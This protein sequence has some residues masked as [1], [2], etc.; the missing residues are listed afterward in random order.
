M[1]TPSDGAAVPYRP[2]WVDRLTAWIG[3]L[4]GPAFLYYLGVGLALIGAVAAS[5]WV[6]GVPFPTIRPFYIFF[7]AIIPYTLGLIHLLDDMA[8]EA[9][10]RFDPVLLADDAE[11]RTMSYRLST[12]PVG[13][14]LVATLLGLLVGLAFALLIPL[15]ERVRL[16]GLAISPTSE[17]VNSGLLVVSWATYGVLFY[18]T[19]HQ[20]REIT[21]VL[22]SHTRINL[23]EVSPIYGFSGVTALT[24]VGIGLVSLGWLIT[25]PQTAG[26]FAG[27][28]PHLIFILAAVLAFLW[29]LLDV[30]RLLN[31]EKDRLLGQNARL[32]ET[33]GAELHRRV[34][35]GE[36]A[37]MSDI[38]DALTGLETER[39]LIEGRPT[40]PWSPQTP[41]AVAA[42]L[43]LPLL[44]W[45]IQR[46]AETLLD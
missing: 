32:L 30:H 11:Q 12:L 24:A 2:S 19:L 33:T 25:L 15:Q 13:P 37:G 46:L 14:T 22:S 1:N 27:L 43:L 40:W 35:S 23:F 21:R 4:P 6:S 45:G 29:P 5:Q 20:L 8:A 18:H 39:R 44:I 28:L 10:Q 31:R 3:R 9:L 16:T 7:G 26:S 36:L 34:E 38:N 17:R 41:R 42:G